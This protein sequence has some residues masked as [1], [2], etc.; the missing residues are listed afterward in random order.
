MVNRSPR[1]HFI[2][3]KDPVPILQEDGWAPGPVWRGGK[4]RPHRDS[5]PDLPARS[6]SLYRLSYPAHKLNEYYP[7]YTIFVQLQHLPSEDYF[8]HSVERIFMK[9]IYCCR[10]LQNCP[11]LFGTPGFVTIWRSDSPKA[12]ECLSRISITFLYGS[13]SILSSHLHPSVATCFSTSEL[14]IRV[15]SLDTDQIGYDV[16]KGTENIVLF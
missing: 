5:M 16:I 13:F 3:G 15:L 2:Q 12:Y 4:S 8:T 10:W 9:E 7:I 14:F 1:P 6:Q 11:A